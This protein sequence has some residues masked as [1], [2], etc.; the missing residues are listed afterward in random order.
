[1]LAFATCAALHPASYYISPCHNFWPIATIICQYLSWRYPI[2]LPQH[3]TT[4]TTA[5]KECW[6]PLQ[7]RNQDVYQTA[8]HWKHCARA[9]SKTE[10]VTVRFAGRVGFGMA[11]LLNR[12]T[13]NSRLW[14]CITP[15]AATNV[16]TWLLAPPPPPPK[17]KLRLFNIDYT[18]CNLFFFF[19]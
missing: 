12:V 18:A 9:D 13:A 1:M 15:A 17:L 8:W 16:R 2:S 6:V 5:M 10:S 11:E 7:K 14:N 4:T 19:K 3:T